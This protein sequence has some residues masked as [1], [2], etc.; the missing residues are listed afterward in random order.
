MTE[1]ESKQFLGQQLG[2]VRI[3]LAK[4]E[5]ESSLPVKRA[6]TQACLASLELGFS[7]YLASVFELARPIR[8]LE[9]TSMQLPQAVAKQVELLKLLDTESELSWLYRLCLLA[10]S[11]HYTHAAWGQHPLGA[12]S[13]GHAP[14]L[15]ASNRSFHAT[16]HWSV[17]NPEDISNIASAAETFL[18]RYNDADQEY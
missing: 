9:F 11:L 15:I 6:L 3:L 2:H 4:L 1:A 7:H 8:L 17:A 5:A 18:E 10:E 14:S 13:V 12:S 16:P